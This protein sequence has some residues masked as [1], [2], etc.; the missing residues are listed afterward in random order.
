ME[1]SAE[2]EAARTNHQRRNSNPFAGG[3]VGVRAAADP[4]EAAAFK[5]DAAAD[6]LADQLRQKMGGSV[7]QLFGRKGSGGGD[8]PPPPPEEGRMRGH[9][10]G[11]VEAER[12][13]A[14]VQF[15]SEENRRLQAALADKERSERRAEERQ[16]IKESVLVLPPG[17]LQPAGG[18][19]RAVR[20][21]RLSDRAR[22]HRRRDW[23]RHA[24]RR[25]LLL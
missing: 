24:G 23:R 20:R 11:T 5:I 22:G 1:G 10:S 9:S 17:A 19:A 7:E 4:F 6:Q 16:E 13:R 8:A 3:G 25:R 2:P 15:L 14:E 12:L 18:A 21:R